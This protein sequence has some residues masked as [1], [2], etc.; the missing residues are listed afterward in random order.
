MYF[1]DT[2]DKLN[3]TS[4]LLRWQF[5]K[6]GESTVH[7]IRNNKL[8]IINYAN[9]LVATRRLLKQKPQKMST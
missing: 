2:R 4:K 8:N 3:I 7:I 6:V 1:K 5:Y 9:S